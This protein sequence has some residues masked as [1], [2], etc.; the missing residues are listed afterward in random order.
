MESYYTLLIF[1]SIW[2]QTMNLF[3]SGH[4]AEDLTLEFS[5]CVRVY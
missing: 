5:S 3:E 1:Y 4:D 2:R